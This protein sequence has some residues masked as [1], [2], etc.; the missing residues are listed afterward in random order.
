MQ[1]TGDMPPNSSVSKDQAF[2]VYK[3]LNTPEEMLVAGMTQMQPVQ[4]TQFYRKLAKQLHPD[5]NRHPQAKEAFQIVYAAMGE[6][7]ANLKKNGH[8]F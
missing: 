6:A 1:Q 4:L 8:K 2:L 5:K 3:F 7:Q